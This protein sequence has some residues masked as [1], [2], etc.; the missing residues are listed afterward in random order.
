M[1]IFQCMS[2]IFSVVFQ[3]EPL[4]FCTNYLTLKGT[5]LYSIDILRDLRFKS[6]EVFLNP[7]PPP[8]P[9]FLLNMCVLDHL[10]SLSI[11]AFL[12]SFFNLKSSILLLKCR[13]KHVN[14][15][16]NVPDLSFLLANLYA[17]FN[18]AHGKVPIVLSWLQFFSDHF[19]TWQGYLLS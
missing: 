19:N 12:D 6:S 7:P 11:L 14:Q 5:F 17:F 18:F 2:N 1:H 9:P 3:K 10:M 13:S 16:V 8:P 4:K 15:Y